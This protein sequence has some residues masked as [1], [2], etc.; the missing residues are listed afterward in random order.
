MKFLRW[1]IGTFFL[2]IA[3]IL[4]FSGQFIFSIIFFIFFY[5]IVP[6]S[7]LKQPNISTDENINKLEGSNYILQTNE[8]NKFKN[9]LKK[10]FLLEKD[11]FINNNKIRKEDAFYKF[12]V[13]KNYVIDYQIKHYYKKF[14]FVSYLIVEGDYINKGEKLCYLTDEDKNN[15]YIITSPKS[16]YV[17][18]IHKNGNEIVDGDKLAIFHLEGEYSKENSPKNFEYFHYNYNESIYFFDIKWN[19][20]DGDFVNIGDKIY[21]INKYSFFSSNSIS[22]LAKKS[23]FIDINFGFKVKLFDIIYTIRDSDEKRKEKFINI[24]DIS[25]DQFTLSKIIKWKYVGTEYKKTDG[26][27]SYSDDQNYMLMFSLNYLKNK[28]HI[29]FRTNK[30]EINL[31]QNDLISFLFEDNKTITFK[32]NEKPITLRDEHN[33]QILETKLIITN[34]ELKIFEQ[35]K[36]IKWRITLN[37]DYDIFGGNIGLNPYYKNKNNLSIVI[38]K[39]TIDYLDTVHKEIEN[40]KPIEIRKIKEKNIKND[41]CFVYLMKDMINNF[42]KIG[43]SSNPKYREKTLQSEKPSIELIKAKKFPNRKIAESFE[44][45]LHNAY[46]EKRIRGEWFNL[47]EKEILDIRESLD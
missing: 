37:N 33:N 16:G 28:D 19:I 32:I 40:Y 31:K 46:K 8:N 23:G 34:E 39:F 26:I 13:L 10:K 21:T 12:N 4:L 1:F 42:Y 15:K 43:I 22:N 47:D 36:F 7:Y 11:K 24:P 29:V 14:Y 18:Y 2:L 6:F 45:A 9:E 27:Y 20:N 38:K 35:N 30:K 3:V 5:L 17:E 44:K 41:E 25:L